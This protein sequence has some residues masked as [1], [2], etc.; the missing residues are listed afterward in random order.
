MVGIVVDPAGDLA[1]VETVRSAIFD[2]GMVP[3]LIGPRGGKLPNG[4]PVQRTFLTARSVEFDVVLLSGCPTPGS[5]ALP[6]RDTKAGQ[7]SA[8]RVDPRVMLMVHEAFRHAK[9]V[10]AF[11]EGVTALEAC[12][13]SGDDAGVVAG[14]DA[15]AVLAEVMGLMGGHRVWERIPVAI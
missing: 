4:M 1:G 6:S 10:A 13:L 9:V 15:S 7:R 12:G 11:G 14:E 3:L 2:A 8:P 5:D